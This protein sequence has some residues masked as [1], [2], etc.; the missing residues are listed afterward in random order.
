MRVHTYVLYDTYCSNLFSNLPRLS[1]HKIPKYISRIFHWTYFLT[2][3]PWPLTNIIRRNSD[4][5]R[6]HFLTRCF[7]YVLDTWVLQY[8]ACRTHDDGT[9]KS[10]K[11][12][13]GRC[14]SRLSRLRMTLKNTYR[15]NLLRKI[16]MAGRR[17]TAAA[18]IIGSSLVPSTPRRCTATSF[19]ATSKWCV[20]KWRNIP[21]IDS[22]IFKS[23]R[24]WKRS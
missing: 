9:T 18:R 22:F 8:A 20:G 19:L 21:E 11:P 13:C 6:C 17:R 4:N 3:R 1:S 23:D 7:P 14:W 15:K 2:D 16:L 12:F 24:F 5:S 10:N